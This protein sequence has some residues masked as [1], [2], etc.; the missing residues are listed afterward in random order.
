MDRHPHMDTPLCHAIRDG[1]IDT[2]RAMLKRVLEAQR[3]RL[4]VVP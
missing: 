4:E 3:A 1:A 2:A